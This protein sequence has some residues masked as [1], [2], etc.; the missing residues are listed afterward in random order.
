MPEIKFP[1]INYGGGVETEETTRAWIEFVEKKIQ[2]FAD[3]FEQLTNSLT[4]LDKILKE[5]IAIPVLSLWKQQAA[6]QAKQPTPVTNPEN[7]EIV[8]L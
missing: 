3:T 5:L 6:E 8:R 4:E 7:P 2:E 1:E